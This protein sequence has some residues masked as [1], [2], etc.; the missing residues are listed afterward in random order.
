MNTLEIRDLFFHSGFDLVGFCKAEIPPLDKENIQDW[1]QKKL[2]GEMSWYPKNTELRLELKNLGFI[3]QSIIA[4]GKIYNT[5]EYSVISEKHTFLFSRYAVG[6]D[7]HIVLKKLANPCLQKLKKE[8]PNYKFRQ[9]VDSLPIPEKIL[10]REAG[11]GWIGKNTNLIHPEKGSYFFIS[12]ILTD[13]QLEFENTSIQDRCGSCRKCIDACPTGALF[14]EYKIDA[15]KCISHH[16]I[17]DRREELSEDI[18][19]NLKGWIYGCDICQSVCPWNEKAERLNRF[20]TGTDFTPHSIFYKESMEFLNTNKDSFLD[21]V[22][23]SAVSRLTYSMFQ[24]NIRYFKKY[25]HQETEFTE[26]KKE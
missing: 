12:I 14:D 5:Q 17:E 13:L 15:G 2:Y 24:R 4:L 8:F 20:A 26:D 3:P 18:Q 21:W 9:G 6:K 23:E 22:K 25:S 7:Y 10:A 11:L 1:I 16:T 19:K